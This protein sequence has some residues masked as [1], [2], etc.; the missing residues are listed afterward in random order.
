MGIGR[1]RKRIGEKGKRKKWMGGEAKGGD[2]NGRKDKRGWLPRQSD[3]L[4][5]PIWHPS[6]SRIL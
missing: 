1:S 4:D 5:P 3:E 6:L 2:R